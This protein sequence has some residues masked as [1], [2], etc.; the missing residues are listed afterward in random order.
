MLMGMFMKVIGS[1][2][3]QMVME[4]IC[5]P[6]DLIMRESGR[7]INS[8]VM[9]ARSGLTEESIEE[10]TSKEKSMEKDFSNG[11]MDQITMEI[12][13]KT[14]FKVK[15]STNG[16]MGECIR[17][18]GKKTKCMEMASSLGKMAGLTKED[19]LRIRNKEKEYSLGQMVENT[20]AIGWMASNTALAIITRLLEKSRKENGPMVK[21][22][23]GSEKI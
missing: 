14:L 11:Q 1:Q 12:F 17:E 16:K 10:N 15:V 5:M 18:I 21:G 8:T 2:T 13:M 9:G 20:M 6:M 22:P 3:K 4:L 7:R 23:S 19:M